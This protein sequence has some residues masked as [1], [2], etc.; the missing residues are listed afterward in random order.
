MDLIQTYQHADRVYSIDIRGNL[1]ASCGQDKKAKVWDMEKDRQVWEF[2]H[3]DE[4]YCVKLFDK[5]LLTSSLDKSVQLW[6]LESGEQ[7][8]R[9][10]HSSGCYN[11]DIHKSLLAVGTKNTVELWDIRTSEKVEEFKL[12]NVHRDLRFNPSGSELVV[13]LGEGEVFII[14]MN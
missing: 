7:R 11:F 2:D 1:I 9:M 10:E 12:G 3:M 6:D 14:R 13:G 8:H 4:V 5:Y